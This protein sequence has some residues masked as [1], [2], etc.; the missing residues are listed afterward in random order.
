MKVD[1]AGNP[2][3][4]SGGRVPL[5]VTISPGEVY[6]FDGVTVTGLQRLRP[7]YVTKRF[8]KLSGKRYNPEAVDEKFREMMQTGLVQ[9]APDQAGRRS[10]NNTLHLADRG[11]GSEEQGV[12]LLVRLRARMP[13]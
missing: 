10:S 11:R 13:A 6:Y 7:S 5:R 8:A 2:E 9:R 12:R 1:A 3:A 4:A